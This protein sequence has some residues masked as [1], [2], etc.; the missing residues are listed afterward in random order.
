MSEVESN[1]ILTLTDE[2]GN[3]HEFEVIQVLEIE[4]KTY[5]IL[6]PAEENSNDEDEAIILRMDKDGEG[7]DILSYIED[8]AEWDMVAEVYDTLY[9]QE[10]GGN[11]D[12][13]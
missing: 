2:E 3:D 4:D 5:T 11:D 13:L 1:Q 7:N 8:D 12:N 6:M 10:Q 9:F